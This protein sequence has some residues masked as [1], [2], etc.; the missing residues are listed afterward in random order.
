[1]RASFSETVMIIVFLA[2]ITIAGFRI[3]Q[4]MIGPSMSNQMS[5]SSIHAA[6]VRDSNPLDVLGQVLGGNH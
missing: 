3:F 4:T 5:L 6:Q 1:M 2:F